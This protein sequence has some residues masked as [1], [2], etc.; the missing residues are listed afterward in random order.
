MCPDANIIDRIVQNLLCEAL[1]L[2]SSR[3][4]KCLGA[5]ICLILV[6]LLL[7]FFNFWFLDSKSKKK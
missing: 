4:I 1:S 5:D 3:R 6:F 2:H 7:F